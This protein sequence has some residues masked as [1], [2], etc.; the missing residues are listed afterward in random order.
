VSTVTWNDALQGVTPITGGQ[1]LPPGTYRL[2]LVGGEGKINSSQAPMLSL[3]FEVASGP[4]AGRKAFYNENLPK[5]N[6]DQ[7]R[8]R[9]G[10]FLGLMEAFG[11]TGAQ[12]GQMFGG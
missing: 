9:M 12:L 2:R 1:P 8:Q 11:I 6:T 3:E 7:D 10:Y 5:G 4:L